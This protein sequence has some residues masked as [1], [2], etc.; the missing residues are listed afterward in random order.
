MATSTLGV[1]VDDTLRERLK[2]AAVKLGCTPHWLHKQAILSY[3]DAIERGQLPAEIS[4]LGASERDEAGDVSV[5][6]ETV[7]PFYEFAHDI[8]P[9]S[10]LRAAITSAYRRPETECVPMLLDQAR[11]PRPKETHALAQRLVETLR[12]KRKSGGVEGLIQ[13]FSL[14]SQEGVALMC[15][16]E[17]L[18]RIPDRATRDALIRDKIS[19]GDWRSHMGESP[20]LFVNAATWGLMLTGRLVGVNSEQSLSRALTRLIGK[21]GEPLI[22]KGVNIAMRMMGEQ[23]VAGQTISS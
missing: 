18:L 6:N 10:V 3:I 15:L 7:P 20:S 2:A 9:Q 8:Q 13:E 23:F 16:A 14:S 1:K 22:R 19:H 4:Y 11:S 21:G 17:A 5:A 12:G